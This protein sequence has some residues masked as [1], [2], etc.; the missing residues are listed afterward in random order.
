MKELVSMIKMVTP[1]IQS[2]VDLEFA[3]LLGEPEPGSAL[4][5]VNLK[6]GDK[7]VYDYLEHGEAGVAFDHLIYMVEET[8]I[9]VAPYL[10][11]TLFEISDLLL[12]QNVSDR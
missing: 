12:Q 6:D 3:K 8:G 9:E 11:E 10:R 7:I 4:D 5:Q 1:E 2:L